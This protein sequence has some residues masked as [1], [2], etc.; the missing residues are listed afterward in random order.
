M[1]SSSQMRAAR[2]LLGWSA[3]DLAKAAS[4]GSA[5]VKRY[6]V[7]EGVPEGNIKTLSAIKK[8]LELA[9]IEFLGD[10]EKTPGVMLHIKKQ[11]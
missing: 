11:G 9:G 1:V 5:T 7:Q 10:P 4:V 3:L 2:S 6:E 8:A